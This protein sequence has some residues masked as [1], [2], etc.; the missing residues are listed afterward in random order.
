[1]ADLPAYGDDHDDNDD[2]DDY[3]ST[4]P[5]LDRYRDSAV[6]N[7]CTIYSE[8]WQTVNHNRYMIYFS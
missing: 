1:M 8:T 4:V 3:V 2:R 7:C 6:V 5:V